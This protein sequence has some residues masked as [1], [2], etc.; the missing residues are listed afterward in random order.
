MYHREDFADIWTKGCWQKE[1]D[2]TFIT[3]QDGSGC[4]KDCPAKVVSYGKKRVVGA[5]EN[6]RR[7]DWLGKG[8]GSI[9]L[10]G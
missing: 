2:D 4:L 6:K 9:Q 8:R 3:E 5:P 10:H 1:Y 7:P